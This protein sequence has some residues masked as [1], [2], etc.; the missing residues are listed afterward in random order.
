MMDKLAE[1][2]APLSIIRGQSIGNVITDM[3]QGTGIEKQIASLVDKV[4]GNGNGKHEM[5]SPAFNQLKEDVKSGKRK[6]K[7]NEPKEDK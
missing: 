1:H 3:F 6:V 7:R 4:N 2:L 5:G